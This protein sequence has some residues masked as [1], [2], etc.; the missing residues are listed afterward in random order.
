MPSPPA[1]LLGGLFCKRQ[2]VVPDRDLGAGSYEALGD[3]APKT[4]RAAGDN[5][6]T[7]VQIDL[8]HD[9]ESFRLKVIMVRSAPLRASRTMSAACRSSFETR[10]SRR[11]S[12]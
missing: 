6:A 8:V 7:A 5:G 10:R 1:D 11:S 12:G 9:G 3:R 4:L 2:V